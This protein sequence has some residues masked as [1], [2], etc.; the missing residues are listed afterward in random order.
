[1]G[2]KKLIISLS[3]VLAIVIALTVVLCVLFVPRKL[4]GLIYTNGIVKIEC[5][6]RNYYET[7]PYSKTYVLD[8]SKWEDFIKKTRNTKYKRING[9]ILCQGQYK[10]TLYYEDGTEIHFDEYRC[11]KIKNDELIK[12]TNFHST[13][14][15]DKYFALFIS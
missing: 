13:V 5:L 7:A 14:A 10:Y 4:S 11:S 2:K 6:E 1:M 9:A 15:E 12:R 8:E 3:V